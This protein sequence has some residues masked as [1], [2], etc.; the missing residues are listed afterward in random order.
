[1]LFGA[2]DGIPNDVQRIAWI[3]YGIAQDVIDEPIVEMAMHRAVRHQSSDFAE[4]FERLSPSQ[5]RVLRQLAHE[6]TANIY[7]KTFLD[8]V[9]VANSNA[10]RTAIA[11]LVHRELVRRTDG[12]W[13]VANA[14]LRSWLTDG[15]VDAPG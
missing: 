8:A 5:Q 4:R 2:V 3:A 9:K 12:Q 6:P 13:R 14:F 1:M 7:A 15:T 11:A 10:V